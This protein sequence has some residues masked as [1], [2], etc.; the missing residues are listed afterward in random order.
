MKQ[1]QRKKLVK[2]FFERNGPML[3]ELSKKQIDGLFEYGRLE[4]E[5]WN[6]IIAVMNEKEK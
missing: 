1:R 6:R 2:R 3:R 5:S 4:R